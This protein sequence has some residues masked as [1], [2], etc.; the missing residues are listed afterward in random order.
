M[1][2]EAQLRRLALADQSSASTALLWLMA[3]AA[4]SGAGMAVLRGL[5]AFAFTVVLDLVLGFLPFLWYCRDSDARGFRRS[6]RWNVGMACFIIPTVFFYLWRTRAPGRR[7]VAM[8]AALGCGLLSLLAAGFSMAVAALL[9]GS[10][11]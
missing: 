1:N 6:R 5:P 11:Y 9:M 2:G 3:A 8:L 4:V 10:H 7:G